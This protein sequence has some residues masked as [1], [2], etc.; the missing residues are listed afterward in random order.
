MVRQVVSAA[1]SA[2]SRFLQQAA[3]LEWNIGMIN[4]R[5]IY[6]RRGS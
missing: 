6:G 3:I 1:A 2:E 5:N 4:K